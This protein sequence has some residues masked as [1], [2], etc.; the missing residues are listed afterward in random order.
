[1]RKKIIEEIGIK[2]EHLRHHNLRY[3]YLRGK[4][5][6]DEGFILYYKIKIK[7]S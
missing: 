1:M 3:K 2:R 7:R 4:I 5:I 6:N